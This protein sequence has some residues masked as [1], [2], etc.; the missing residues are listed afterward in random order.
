MPDLW[1]CRAHQTRQSGRNSHPISAEIGLPRL[2][3]EIMRN[4]SNLKSTNIRSTTIIQVQNINLKLNMKDINKILTKEH[5]KCYFFKWCEETTHFCGN[6]SLWS[7]SKSCLHF[8]FMFSEGE[9]KSPCFLQVWW[10]LYWTRYVIRV[11][12]SYVQSNDRH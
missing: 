9:V 10:A 8:S 4:E 3:S 11:I 1:Y 7:C 2:Q 6:M 12:V 5:F